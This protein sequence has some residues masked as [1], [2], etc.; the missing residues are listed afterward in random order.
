MGGI[1]KDLIMAWIESADSADHANLHSYVYNIRVLSS[2]LEKE[3]IELDLTTANDLRRFERKMYREHRDTTAR[4]IVGAAKRFYSWASDQGI[5][6][7]VAK[8]A[9]SKGGWVNYIRAPLEPAD[10]LRIIDAAKSPRD[11]A[12][13]SLAIRCDLKSRDIVSAKSEGL[14]LEKNGG[15]IMLANGSWSPITKACSNDLCE[16]LAQ[17]D[18]DLMSERLFTAEKRSNIGICLKERTLRGIFSDAFRHAGMPLPAGEYATG[19]ACVE[20]AVEEGEPIGV[21]IALC[22]RTY[23]YRKHRE[24]SKG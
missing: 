20:L 1:G 23:H 10:A 8:D 14:I 2:F 11:R 4:S 24:G 6:R 19:S 17:Q 21:I 9:L 3:G 15:E 7:D 13:L 18:Y 12:M 22:D 5:C 16:Y